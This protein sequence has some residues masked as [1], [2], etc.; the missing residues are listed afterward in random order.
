M[1]DTFA[2]FATDPDFAAATPAAP[3]RGRLTSAAAAS[4]FALAG[5]AILTLVSVKTTTRYTYRISANEDGTC[6]FVGVLTGPDNQR[7]YAYLG[8]ISRGVYWHGRKVPKAG[9]IAK[10]APSN[11][12]FD[13]AWRKLARGLLP[14][15]L[16]VWHESSCGRCGRPLT[17]PSSIHQG[18]GP[19]CAEKMG[20]LK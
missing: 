6:H 20:L 8:R 13:W 2:A 10:D 19:D 5:K 3:V 16:E 1:T 7:D 17:V 11:I 14:D 18:F 15:Q 9:D 4:R 12:A